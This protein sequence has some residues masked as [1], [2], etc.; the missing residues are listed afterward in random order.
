MSEFEG[1]FVARNNLEGTVDA[2][3][4]RTI[5]TKEKSR[6]FLIMEWLGIE[7]YFV[8]SYKPSDEVLHV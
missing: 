8:G 3:N 6:R 1:S 7:C 4:K 5:G 2:L